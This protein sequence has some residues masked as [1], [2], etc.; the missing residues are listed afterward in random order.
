MTNAPLE[1]DAL[2]RKGANGSGTETAYTVEARMEYH[3]PKQIN[4]QLFD[5]RWRR[6][7]F[8]ALPAHLAHMGVPGAGGMMAAKL[9]LY[10]YTQAQALRWWFH[11]NADA[12]FDGICLETRLVKHSVKYSYESTVE[13]AHAV[14][15]SDDRSSVMPDPKN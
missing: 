13:S 5:N 11:A 15:G 2:P 9:D 1:T 8:T 4:G 3:S 12:T 6:V 7:S 14:I 10:S